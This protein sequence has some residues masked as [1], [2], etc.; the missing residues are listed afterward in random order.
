MN[1]LVFLDSNVFIWG[2][3]RPESNSGKILDLMDEGKIK[4]VV[5]EKVIEELRTYF[6]NHYNKDVWSGVFS[7]ISALVRIVFREEIIEEIRK[8]KGKIKEKDVEHLATVRL[9]KLKYLVSYD[10]DYKQIEEYITPKK[11]IKELGLKPADSEY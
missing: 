1:A 9:L 10:D 11:F 8:V 4:I 6:I 7:H 3:N 2:Y 5:S